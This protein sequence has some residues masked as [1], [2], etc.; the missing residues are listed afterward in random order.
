[1]SLIIL[2]GGPLD[3][4]SLK[5]LHG[6]SIVVGVER[7]GEKS[8]AMYAINKAR[9]EAEFCGYRPLATTEQADPK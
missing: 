8:Q 3:G 2:K 7:A 6:S 1:M 9:T 4:K 5:I